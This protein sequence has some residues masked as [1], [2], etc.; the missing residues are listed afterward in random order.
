MAT[1]FQLQSGNGVLFA[2]DKKGK[3][4]APDFKGEILLES[5]QRIKLSAWT[6]QTKH[7]TMMISL[8]ENNYVPEGQQQ[9]PKEVQ[10]GSG[11]SQNYD[12]KD[13]PF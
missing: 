8:K 3:Q 9:Y 13:I 10:S 1:V 11:F 7:G 12:D 4:S 2:N 6:K 5:G